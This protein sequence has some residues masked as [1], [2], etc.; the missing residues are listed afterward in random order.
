LVTIDASHKL[1]LA[2]IQHSF[3]FVLGTTMELSA[4][5]VDPL[6]IKTDCLIVPVGE[7]SKLSSATSAINKATGKLISRCQDNGDISGKLGSTLMLHEPSGLAAR[8]LLLVGVGKEAP[9]VEQF[10]KICLAATKGISGKSIK[11]AA[12]TLTQVKLASHDSQWAAAQLSRLFVEA[13]YNFRKAGTKEQGKNA[14]NKVTVICSDRKSLPS[15]KAGIKL[16]SSIAAGVNRTRY[17][18]DLPGNTCTPGYLASQARALGR[19]HSTISTKVLSEKQMLEL[20]M[21]ALLSVTAGSKQ[22]AHLI[23]MEYKGAEKSSKPIVLVGKGVT[24][25]SGGISLKP[26]AKMD[27]MK[28][29]MC[30]AASVFGV[31]ESL[32]TIK[33]KINVVGLVPTVENMPSSTATKPGDVVTSMS[34]KTIEVLN[35][36]AEGRLI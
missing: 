1:A 32:A 24:F 3:S 14:L 7:E 16:G 12:T 2:I 34:G 10:I 25:D 33:P 8:R 28:Y 6:T 15:N 21:G 17:L 23:A 20:G 29:D 31:M 22:P 18:G 35:T 26:G 19:K 9:N 27:E 11:I 36:D 5:S 4:R 30:G 13:S